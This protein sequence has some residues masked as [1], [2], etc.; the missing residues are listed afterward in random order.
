VHD[1]GL[2]EAGQGLTSVLDRFASFAQEATDEGSP[3]YARI[4]ADLARDVETAGLL[5]EAPPDQR[6][7]NL[8][9]AAVHRLM[10]SGT[11]H[12]LGDYYPSI[13]GRAALPPGPG[14]SEAFREFC[15]LHRDALVALVR[16]RRTQTNEP[17][18]AALLYPALRVVVEEAGR[19]LAVGEIGASAGLLLRFDRYR[20]RY[21]S[22]PPAGATASPLQLDVELRG[23]LHPPVAGEPPS[24]AWRG[25]LDAN[26]LD[27]RDPAAA[28]WLRALVWPEHEDRRRILDRALEIALTTPAP[29]V[30]G[31]ALDDLHRLV[32][33]VPPP[34]DA[35]LCL[36]HVA[37]A[38]YLPPRRRA[39]LHAAV[40]DLARRTDRPIWLLVGEWG[41]VVES[42][43]LGVLA[44]SSDVGAGDAVIALVRCEPDGS[45]TER[46]LATGQAHGRW[47]QWRD[48]VT[49]SNLED[50]RGSGDD[51][52]SR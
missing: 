25:G 2:G 1:S 16:T 50:A 31:D 4:S 51:G 27:V 39:A 18:R 38:T 37:V 48:R 5:L 30:K 8:L 42:L 26:P 11:A 10:L 24:V 19:P 46:L 28:A 35:A 3:L 29:L 9:F 47:L 21:G 12:R 13:A 49:A 7:P 40:L 33:Q 44:G 41:S 34:D 32:T 36:F 20:Y 17:R 45:R 22:M 6:R 23:R 52:P 43:G 14:A 15:A